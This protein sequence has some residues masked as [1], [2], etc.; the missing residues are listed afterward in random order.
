MPKSLMSGNLVVMIAT[1]QKQH[2][3]FTLLRQ[4]SKA[5]PM[6]IMKVMKT[7]MMISPSLL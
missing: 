5:V 3:F 6:K 4:L 1:V 7:T 2:H